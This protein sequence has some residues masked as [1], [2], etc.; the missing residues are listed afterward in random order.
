MSY[1]AEINKDKEDVCI[2][3]YV[4][5]FDEYIVKDLKTNTVVFKKHYPTEYVKVDKSK[6]V[7]SDFYK[8]ILE[9]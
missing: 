3:T 7:L 8:F 9:E 1:Y 5:S 4:N 2:N 6:E